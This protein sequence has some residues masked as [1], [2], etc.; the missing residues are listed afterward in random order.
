MNT[1]VRISL[2]L[3]LLAPAAL[4]DLR[5]PPP[6][7]PASTGGAQ[8]AYHCELLAANAVHAIFKEIRSIPVLEPG[9]APSSQEIAV[10]EVKQNLA[11]RRYDRMGDPAL[12]PGKLCSVVLAADVP[13]QDATLAGTL[14]QLSPGEEVLMNID[15]IYVFRDSGNENVRA[16]TRFAKVQS[17]QPLPLRS[18]SADSP[19]TPAAPITPA[20]PIAPAISQPSADQADWT[21]VGQSVQETIRYDAPGSEPKRMKVETR[22]EY[23]RKT[24]EKR[25]RKFI[26][27]V[28]VDPQTD[29]PLAPTGQPAAPA[30]APQPAAEPEPTPQAPA[31]ELPPIPDPVSM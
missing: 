4:A 9:A 15:H 3:L 1:L 22:H 17:P 24:K 25:T 29:L 2:P 6:A 30:A 11:H 7:V 20:T 28:E 18:E 16:C 5:I 23:S 8:S 21:I 12:Q 19:T 31:A 14:R 27:D 10:F 13:G 26:N